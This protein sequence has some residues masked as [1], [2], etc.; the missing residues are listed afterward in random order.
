VK[1]SQDSS[2]SYAV[3]SSFRPADDRERDNCPDSPHP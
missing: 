2:A 1:L 3:K